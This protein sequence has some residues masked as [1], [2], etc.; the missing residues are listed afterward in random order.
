MNPRASFCAQVQR[1]RSINY[2]EH[3][4][5]R[6]LMEHQPGKLCGLL[7]MASNYLVP[8]PLLD[9]CGSVSPDWLPSDIE[10][11]LLRTLSW[12]SV[13]VFNPWYLS[14]RGWDLF[15]RLWKALPEPEQ[16]WKS[17]YKPVDNLWITPRNLLK[18]CREPVEKNGTFPQAEFDLYETCLE[19]STAVD[20]Y[21][22][23][24]TMFSTAGY[25]GPIVRTTLLKDSSP[26]RKRTSLSTVSTGPTTTTI[27]IHS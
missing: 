26:E 25:H 2:A 22:V 20:N 9:F 10:A 12:E 3:Y 18:T 16:L 6:N 8:F 11:I 7:A 5:Y 1:R 21:P 24:S 19:L 23:L 27:S 13:H 14:M 15:Q 17:P 4:Q